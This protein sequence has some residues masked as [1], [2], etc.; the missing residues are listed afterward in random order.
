MGITWVSLYSDV[1]A[2]VCMCAHA[3][4]KEL[5]VIRCRIIIKPLNFHEHVVCV[6]VCVY[7]YIHTYVHMSIDPYSNLQ[8]E[9]LPHDGTTMSENFVWPLMTA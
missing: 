1:C 6:C 4:C 7:I 9:L 5:A 8:S 2:C 3:C